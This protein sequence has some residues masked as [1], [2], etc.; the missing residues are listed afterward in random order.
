M[1]QIQVVE[2]MKTRFM[3]QNFFFENRAFYEIMWKNIVEQSRPQMTVWRMRIAC[4]LIKGTHTA[5][6]LCNTYCFSIAA[7]QYYVMRKLPIL[8]CAFLGTVFAWRDVPGVV[9]HVFLINICSADLRTMH[10]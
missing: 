3:L 10:K 2:E 8:Y 9:I 1:F 7:T 4:W 5:L 6:K